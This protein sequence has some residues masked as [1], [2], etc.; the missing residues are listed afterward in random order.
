MSQQK[1][2][3]LAVCAQLFASGG[4]YVGCK[5]AYTALL[6]WLTQHGE[7]ALTERDE[8][9]ERYR[10][11]LQD[12]IAGSFWFFRYNLRSRKSDEY[13]LYGWSGCL[14]DPGPTPKGPAPDT[15]AARVYEAWTGL[16]LVQL[17]EI[18]AKKGDE[19]GQKDG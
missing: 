4:T 9:V 8:C 2:L 18:K 13:R 14:Y 15:G 17:N 5:A 16:F 12:I 6:D 10:V 1:E 11:D 19:H 3:E 7:E